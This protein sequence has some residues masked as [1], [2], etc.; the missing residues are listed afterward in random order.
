MAAA[1][2]VAFK[3][4]TG[5]VAPPGM[6]P[7]VTAGQMLDAMRRVKREERTV[8]VHAENAPIVDF[9]TGR[10]KAEGRT[11]V[12]AWDEARPWFSELE[13]VQRVSLLAEVTGCRTV[14]AHVTAP[15]SVVAVRDGAPAGRR[16][17]GRDVPALP[18]PDARGDGRRLAPEVEPSEPRPRLGRRALAA[19]A[20]GARAHDRLRPRPAAEGPGRGRLD[21]A[22]RAP[23]TDSRR[24]CRSSALKRCTAGTSGSGSVVDLLVDD[25]CAA[26]SASIR[27][28]ERSASAPMPTSPSSRPTGRRDP[29]RAGARV[30]RAAEVVP[31][32][33]TR[34]DASIPSTPSSADRSSS[35][36]ARSSANPVLA[37]SWHGRRPWR[38]MQ[39]T[40]KESE[41]L[42][43]FTAA[44]LARRRLA[45]RIPLSHPDAIA[46]ASDIVLER[47]RAGRSYD[48]A[49]ASVH[50]LFSRDQL[51][52]GR[53]G[54]AG[55][56]APGRGVLR[57]R[58]PARAPRA[59]G[60]SRVRPG[61]LI[62][63]DGPVPAARPA[64]A[65]DAPRSERGRFPA[66]PRA[67]TSR[68]RWASATLEF[69]REGLDG[70]AACAPGG[71]AVRI[72][73]G[74]EVELEVMS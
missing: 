71:A 14:I 68:S 51:L 50:G 38:L 18:V 44:E 20:P 69:P 70:C 13:A 4:F 72:E 6:Y 26:S 61:E 8:V 55:G 59:A 56:A 60:P 73:P 52:P 33:R 66:V 22:A 21:A 28:R 57:R 3:L 63:G 19:A 49:R 43:I 24:C 35:P 2:A 1:G 12:A 54:A 30:P 32:R 40:P 62:P 47:A 10:L 36:R 5:G 17:L 74:A 31:L 42:L 15:Q 25:A 67:R 41:R 46:L 45:E 58:H 34:D 65:R 23:A 9:E 7:G 27:A 11:D 53:C 29:R 37:S 48:D 64:A 39:L 16:R